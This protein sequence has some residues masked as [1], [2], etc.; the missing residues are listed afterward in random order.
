MACRS[1]FHWGKASRG[2]A[3]P[4]QLGR[5]RPERGE[6][7]LSI[8]SQVAEADALLRGFSGG[9]GHQCPIGPRSAAIRRGDLRAIQP[10]V[11]VDRNTRR[12]LRLLDNPFVVLHMQE[13]AGPGAR[14]YS[15][16]CRPAERTHPTPLPSPPR[17][18]TG[19]HLSAQTREKRTQLAGIDLAGLGGGKLSVCRYYASARGILTRD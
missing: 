2:P 16:R 7:S 12:V 18:G 14:S 3:P 17:L 4:G 6:E 5:V 8:P 9:I 1:S 10:K 11:A 19:A 15:C 13:L